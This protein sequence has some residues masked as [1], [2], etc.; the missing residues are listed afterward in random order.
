[1]DQAA[2]RHIS[3][4]ALWIAT[5]RAMESER[6]D[7]LFYDP[8]A[9]QLAGERGEQIAAEL[10]KHGMQSWPLVVRTQVLDELILQA[11]EE[12]GYDTVL[13]LAA[14]LDTRPYRLALPATLRWAEVDLPDMIEY[15]REALKDATCFCRLERCALDLK[16]SEARRALFARIG[17]GATKMLV[18][19][20]GL[21]LYLHEEEVKDLAW[22]LYREPA[23]KRWLTDLASPRLL[24]YMRRIRQQMPGDVEFRFAPADHTDFF[25]SRSWHAKA[26]HS[27]WED[28]KRLNRR[29]VPL[30]WLWDLMGWIIPGA[31]E[32]GRKMSGIVVLERG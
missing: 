13:N 29:E 28:A 15:K 6:P 5:Y 2:I 20:E 25:L 10:A 8:F 18:I 1:M 16:D 3:D 30:A 7:A 14:G 31:R 26:F 9:R 32:Q 22:D 4:T 12:D 23:A 17:A 24:R 19:T 27:T 11:V 21:L